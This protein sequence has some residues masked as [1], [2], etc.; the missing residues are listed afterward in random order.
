MLRDQVGVRVSGCRDSTDGVQR[1]AGD[2]LR[3]DRRGEVLCRGHDDAR[4]RGR[5][6]MA[7]G[8]AEGQRMRGRHSGAVEE[9]VRQAARGVGCPGRESQ[10]CNAGAVVSAMRAQGD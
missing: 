6:G 1:R 10:P 5:L 8:L 7:R 9:T 2:S 4:Q 3:G